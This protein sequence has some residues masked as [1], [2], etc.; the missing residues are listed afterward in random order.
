MDITSAM[1][2]LA[3]ESFIHC[4]NWVTTHWTTGW[5][6]TGL[7]LNQTIIGLLSCCSIIKHLRELLLEPTK[8][9][10]KKR[11]DQLEAT[12]SGYAEETG[13]NKNAYDAFANT[14]RKA[15]KE[16][17]DSVQHIIEKGIKNCLWGTFIAIA[18][19]SLGMYNH[20]GPFT[21]VLAWPIGVI[22]W[23]ARR[24]KN[25]AV[26]EF[27]KAW[28]SIETI[29]THIYQDFTKATSKS[30]KNTPNHNNGKNKNQSKRNGRFN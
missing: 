11:K 4:W 23:K 3:K 15:F 9:S 1:L 27:N 7:F 6:E 12:A 28:E 22:L 29:K 16:Y 30:N 24:Q 13:E 25:I 18:Y 8:Q 19:M 5:C 21:L 14:S 26:A 2:T 10:L 17:D 20:L